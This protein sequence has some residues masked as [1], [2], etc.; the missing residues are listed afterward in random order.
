MVQEVVRAGRISNFYFGNGIKTM[1]I[2]TQL[3]EV[4]HPMFA[5]PTLNHNRRFCSISWKTYYNQL[6]ES[7][8][9]LVG[10]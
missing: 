9:K 4:I 5:F 2:V 1:I 7:K 8:G 3:Y 6:L 10:E